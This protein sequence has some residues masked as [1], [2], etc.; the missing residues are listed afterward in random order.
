MAVIVNYPI[1]TIGAWWD[2][3]SGDNGP[4]DFFKFGVAEL[5]R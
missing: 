4:V 2:V 3:F 5:A 1:G